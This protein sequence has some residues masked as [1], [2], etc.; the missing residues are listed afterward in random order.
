MSTEPKKDPAVIV[1]EGYYRLRNENEILR[2]QLDREMARLNW[3]AQSYDD[4]GNLTPEQEARSQRTFERSFAL[5]RKQGASNAVAVRAA[6]DDAMREAN[7]KG[8]RDDSGE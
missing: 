7:I 2:N 5:L 3:M 1:A 8:S 4:A 6:I